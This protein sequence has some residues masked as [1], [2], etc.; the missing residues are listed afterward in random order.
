VIE[1]PL[2]TSAQRVDRK[3]VAGLVLD[4]LK[5]F[6]ILGQDRFRPGWG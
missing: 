4:I 6:A 2:G 3:K 1:I 5:Q